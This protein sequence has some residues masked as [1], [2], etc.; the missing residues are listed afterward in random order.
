MRA[1]GK[2][3][4]RRP[5][6]LEILRANTQPPC[7]GPLANLPIRMPACAND[8]SNG[9]PSSARPS[10]VDP[11]KRMLERIDEMMRVVLPDFR[12]SLT[13]P[14]AIGRAPFRFGGQGQTQRNSI[15]CSYPDGTLAHLEHLLSLYQFLPRVADGLEEPEQ[16]SPSGAF[17]DSRVRFQRSLGSHS[18]AS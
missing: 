6:A 15:R 7:G 14:V 9:H 2:S 17:V 1:T 12:V 11:R 4:F 10:E 16:T 8:G 18:S 13:R 5:S 3:W